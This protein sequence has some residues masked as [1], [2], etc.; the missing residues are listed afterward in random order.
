MNRLDRFFEIS[1]R[2]SSVGAELRGGL[3]TFIAMAYI[4]VLNPIILSGSADVDGNR[5]EFAQV[6]AVTALAAG[7]MT[8]LF[9]LIARLPFAFAAGLGINSFV[10]TTLVGDLTWAEAMGL[11][12]IN[13]LIIVLLAVTGLRRLVFDAVPM[14]L[15]LAITAGIG[16]F[17]LFI[18]LVDAGFIGSTGA[19]SPPVGLGTGGNGSIGTV[20]AV[21]FAFT[22]L[23]TG[24]LVARKIRGGILIGLI[25]GTV[26]AVVVEAIWHLGSAVDNPGGWSLS[27]PTLSGS[28]FAVPDLSL[29]GA[30]SMDSFG[31][32]GAIAAVMFVFTLVFANFFDAM[33]TMTGLSR[34]AGLSDEHGNF[35]R[36][37]AAL[38]V[39]G[40]GAVVGGA[41][42]ASSNTVFIESGAGIG[43]G[44]RT[45]LANMVTGALFL[46]AMF[47]S[48]LASIV[49]TEVAAA[50]L[51]VVGAMMVSHLRHID[52]S[53]FSVALPVVL[54]VAT[55]PFS[56]SIA[57]GI[58]IGFISWVVLRSAAGKAREIS[59]LLW[60]V[61]AGF[62][63]YF[64]RGWI[65]SLLGI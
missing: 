14:Q 54:T 39:E 5:L 36:L 13:G 44:A 24:I 61:A 8:I 33:G 25:A 16:L 42:S 30:F 46:A 47:V 35:P 49:P 20:P 58:G 26:V 45:G 43:E 7:V 41:S 32:I 9:G 37:R 48:P 4:I 64:A 63:I 40:A 2:G 6:S 29:V 12:V 38:V 15:K 57:N 56:Y 11:V 34:E 28:P 21:V 59:P 50:A 31:R 51:V 22:L 23:L 65:E 62:L 60:I 18:G 55:M 19:P 53:E 1:A 3:V 27:V 17:I 10:A 52:I